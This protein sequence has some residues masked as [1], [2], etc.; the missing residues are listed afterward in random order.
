MQLIKFG[1]IEQLDTVF[2]TIQH[3]SQLNGFDENNKPI[4]NNNELP[5]LEVKLSEKIHGMNG[6]V[7][8]SNK[9]GF[10]V[11][12]RREVITLDNDN[13]GFAFF[14]KTNEKV[15]LDLINKLSKQYNIN[16]DTHRITLFGEFAGDG[17]QKKSALTG[18]KKKFILFQ[19]FK[20]SNV[21]EE[22]RETDTNWLENKVNNQWIASEEND[23]Y[24]IMNYFTQDIIIDFNQF[25]ESKS[26]LEN[27]VLKI[28]E[29][30]PLGEFFGKK[31][32]IGEGLIGNFL[33]NGDKISFKVKGQKHTNT[34]VYKPKVQ[35]DEL[36]KKKMDC[37]YQVCPA[38][39]LEQFW[40]EIFGFNNEKT[41]DIKYLKD[42]IKKVIQDI[43]KEDLFK[44]SEFNLEPKAIYPYVSKICQKWFIEQL[45]TL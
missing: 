18:F 36:I 6:G 44:I 8:Y 10:Y 37:A 26:K 35:D 5:K 25:E 34:R 2:K 38:F 41:P 4:Y 40:Q 19:Y 29:S 45:K 22:L 12:K 15:L 14:C 3:Y 1:S 39:R 27:L 24:N 20:V 31:G 16:F 9:E 43:N 23:I 32:N 7:N 21:N 42:F 11:Q 17:I 30:S 33:F 28:E 13:G